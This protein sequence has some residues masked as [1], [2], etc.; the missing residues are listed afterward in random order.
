[1]A[2]LFETCGLPTSPDTRN[3]ISS[4]ASAS[5][6]TRRAAPDGETIDLY[7]PHHAPASPLA[8]LARDADLMMSAISGRTSGASP[9]SADLTRLLASRLIA[10][11]A[12][13]GSTLYRLTWKVRATPLRRRYCALLALPLQTFGTVF[14]GWPAPS[15][16]DGERGGRMTP[17]MS[18]R[19]LTQMAR[20]AAGWSTPTARDG[21]RGS[22]P[23]LPT[24]TGQALD[25]MAALAGWATPTAQ[26]AKGPSSTDTREGS[27]DLQTQAGW[28][29]PAARDYRTPNHKALKDRGGGPK[30]EQLQNQA[31]HLI[32]GASLNGSTAPTDGAGLLNQEFSRWLQGVPETWGNYAPMGTRSTR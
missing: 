4:P 9:A 14:T 22:L 3:A 18:G 21:T 32:P 25:Q 19:S 29:T 23:A 2:D 12:G 20:E 27:S 17:N 15:A 31:A 13:C 5:G 26:N 30:G 8:K 7:G 28:A 16:T 1:M 6:R 24:A 11:T 10:R